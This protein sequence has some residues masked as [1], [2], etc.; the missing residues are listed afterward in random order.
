MSAAERRAIATF[1]D[2]AVD[3]DDVVQPLGAAARPADPPGRGR[4]VPHAVALHGP[5]RRADRAVAETRLLVV[6]ILSTGRVEQRLVELEVPSSP[7][8]SSP[9]LRAA[10]Q[11][12]RGRASAS[13][14][15]STALAALLPA[16]RG[17]RAGGR[18][19]RGRR[20]CARRCPT[21]APTSGSRW[22]ARPTWRASATA[23]TPPSARCSR[24]SR[25]TWCCSSCSARPRTG[26]T[27]TVRIGH[28]GPYQRAR[29]DQRRRDRLRPRRRGAR[30][31][32]ASSGPT[33][34]DYP[35]TMA[36]V[37]AVARYVSRILDEA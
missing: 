17:H 37:R 31:A 34:M 30:H 12:G 10:D 7:T 33:R 35:G 4:A 14:T 26:G 13:P 27:V 21:T 8:T 6:L 9:T 22:A 28:E 3:L 18:R 24:R 16:T 11:P 36:A 32:S 29:R 25:S 1:L 20:P 2:G 15:P 19:G 5:P 23:S